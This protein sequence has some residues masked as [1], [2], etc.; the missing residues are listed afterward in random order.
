MIVYFHKFKSGYFTD[1]ILIILV[2]EVL[3]LLIEIFT[4]RGTLAWPT[5]VYDKRTLQKLYSI[6]YTK[7]A[8]IQLRSTLTNF[9]DF[10]K[11]LLSKQ[12]NLIES[13]S[14]LDKRSRP[15]PYQLTITDPKTLQTPN[16]L[17]G[18]PGYDTNPL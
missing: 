10:R 17:R 5:K 2:I 11:L 7:I 18:V 4:Y 1:L 9:I 15:Y 3:E 14:Y 8:D 13:Y 16:S 12:M 6:V